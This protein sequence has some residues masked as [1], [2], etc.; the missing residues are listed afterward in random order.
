MQS[1]SYNTFCLKRSQL[2]MDQ[3]LPDHFD[4]I[5]LGTGLE[6]SIVAAAAARNGH[7]VLH[8]DDNGYYG[9][10]WAAF[11]MEGIQE[12]INKEETELGKED[13][14]GK[15]EEKYA[16]EGEK[17]VRLR[18]SQNRTDVKQEWFVPDQEQE[19]EDEDP[20]EPDPR[21]EEEHADVEASPRHAKQQR[22]HW[23]KK[24]VNDSSRN[25]NLD[26]APR[27]L[28]SRGSMVELL[29]S[30]NISRYTEFKSVS[31][32][33]TLLE[34]GQLE[35]VPSSRADVFATK[36]VSVVEKRILMKF[37]TACLNEEGYGKEDKWKGK[38]YKEFLVHEKLT[39]NLIHFV[40][41]SIAM[42]PGKLA[43]VEE[44]ISATKKF[45][46]SLGRFGN[47]PFLWT[48]FGSGE[49]PQAFCR[50][51]AVFG[52]TYFLGQKVE[53]LVFSV[54]KKIE[55]V[56]VDGMR[57]GCSKIVLNGSS[58]PQEWVTTIE[59][60][61]INRKI[62]LLSDSILPSEREQLT[63]LTIPPDV[64]SSSDS[65][66]HV[67][68]V[69]FSAAVVP[70]EMYC[71]HV[72]SKGCEDEIYDEALADVIKDRD[73]RIWS[74]SFRLKAGK[75]K[76]IESDV[77]TN[78]YICN[79][80]QFELDYD[81]CIDHARRVFMKMYEGEEFLPRAPEPEE[82]I[83]GETEEPENYEGKKEAEEKPND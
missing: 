56:I 20:T 67:E 41:N 18:R 1:V 58:C 48:M 36:R 44:G 57:V 17:I 59:N 13:D 69:G 50:L 54:E 80:P 6:E 42:V 65:F 52:G 70:K 61:M 83:I 37:L 27:L 11:N 40:L 24:R 60:Y 55:A 19:N 35:H 16:K 82:I 31:R 25:F 26:L 64:N 77:V 9:G 15:L 75:F 43:S 4:L 66:T 2:L 14:I 3:P 32:V 34:G 62:F 23:T 5:I 76:M 63:F 73:S 74:L 12:W 38:L 45:L 72:T 46:A 10:D 39:E 8:L 21:T 7:T 33:L 78:L 29:I 22:P 51:C 28:F 79:G 71:L 53:G 30:S 47:T 49:L 68:E 81:C